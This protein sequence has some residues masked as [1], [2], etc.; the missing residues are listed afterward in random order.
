MTLEINVTLGSVLVAVSLDERHP[1]NESADW[2]FNI[3]GFDEVFLHRNV[4]NRS[5]DVSVVYVA[6][7]GIDK[8]NAFIITVVP[9]T[10]T[11]LN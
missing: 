6:L 3:S 1:T 11:Y 7:Y 4:L 2:S 10:G 8:T 9:T 5:H